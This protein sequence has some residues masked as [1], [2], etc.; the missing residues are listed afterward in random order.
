MSTTLKLL[1]GLRNPTLLENGVAEK[2]NN[3]IYALLC[4]NRTSPSTA[5][6]IIS[7]VVAEDRWSDDRTG[8]TFLRFFV[9]NI[10]FTVYFFIPINRGIYSNILKM[11]IK[12]LCVERSCEKN[13]NEKEKFFPRNSS[14]FRDYRETKTIQPRVPHVCNHNTPEVEWNLYFS[15]LSGCPLCNAVHC[16]FFFFGSFFVTLSPR[17]R[18]NVKDSRNLV[19]GEG[20]LAN[21]RTNSP[22]GNSSRSRLWLRA[23][24][25][26]ATGVRAQDRGRWT[27]R[28][29]LQRD[30][31][32][33]LLLFFI[34]IS[35]SNFFFYCPT[36]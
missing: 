21:S 12:I 33:L 4:P 22:G 11:A 18:V 27:R 35:Q 36:F 13:F 8:A 24:R 17:L 32:T 14:S 20:S 19:E 28:W 29:H 26:R 25:R 6:R 10:P 5:F 2:K 30:S 31:S 1:R 34:K 15:S 7:I 3:T 16:Y 9:Q 23:R